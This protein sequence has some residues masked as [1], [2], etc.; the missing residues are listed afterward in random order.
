[1]TGPSEN[2]DI[3]NFY[4]TKNEYIEKCVRQIVAQNNRPIIIAGNGPSL[5]EIDYRR[6]PKDALVMRINNFYFEDKYYLGKHADFVYL[7]GKPD[8]VPH[9]I[10]TQLISQLRHEYTTDYYLGRTDNIINMSGGYLPVI[11]I[12]KTLITNKI[13]SDYMTLR[14][15]PP[16][17]LP[18]SGILAIFTAI[19]FGFKNIYLAGID[20]YSGTE[21]YS[22][23]VGKTHADIVGIDPGRVGYSHDYHNFNIDHEALMLIKTLK[24]ADV[25]SLCENA[26]I[27]GLFP[28]APVVQEE[29]AFQILEK[30]SGYINDFILIEGERES[31]TSINP[32]KKTKFQQRLEQYGP[33]KRF[34]LRAGDAILPKFLAEPIDRFLKKLGIF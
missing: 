27:N 18:T 16:G 11:D 24:S 12:R 7:A 28:V 3:T 9:S 25:Y 30:E 34:L 23:Q 10:H 32:K 17:I 19:S 31:D 6:L 8:V 29:E 4:C 20:L 13:I 5:K 2:T 21:N 22:F 33:V 26:F 1:M 15:M 14:H